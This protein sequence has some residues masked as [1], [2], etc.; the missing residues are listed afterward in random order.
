MVEAA[1]GMSAAFEEN[2]PCRNHTEGIYRQ[3][4]KE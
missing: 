2:P 3:N 1:C 4:F